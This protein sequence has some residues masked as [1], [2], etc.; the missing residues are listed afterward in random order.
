MLD[1]VSDG[2]RTKAKVNAEVAGAFNRRKVA[3]LSIVLNAGFEIL[4]GLACAAGAS[5][6][7]QFTQVAALKSQ[8]LELRNLGGPTRWPW[9]E[10]QSLV[11]QGVSLG[12]D[13]F[14]LLEPSVFVG[15][16][17]GERLPRLGQHFA[18]LKKHMVFEAVKS[19]ASA[20]QSAQYLSIARQRLRFIIVVGE[21]RLNPQRL[22]G[23]DHNL[24]R[25]AVSNQQTRFGV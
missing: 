23:T 24:Q 6:D 2:D 18:S 3:S 1:Q 15:G 8:G 10:W 14:K 21:H 13:T 5:G 16:E 19:D 11:G 7:G 22:S 12:H 17:D 25:F 20:R 4:P 9:R